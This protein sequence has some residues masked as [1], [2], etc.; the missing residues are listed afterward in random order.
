MGSD[1]STGRCSSDLD[2]IVGSEMWQVHL[3]RS[4]GKLMTKAQL[5]AA[6]ANNE[7]G[8]ETLVRPPGAF[9]WTTAG[10]ATGRSPDPETPPEPERELSSS[11]AIAVHAE[12][13]DVDLASGN[14]P[15]E[16]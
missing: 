7:I 5:E 2:A 9:S 1:V 16:A 6:V 3:G 8:L 13:S 4:G 10:A 12:D 14:L 11:N 15:E